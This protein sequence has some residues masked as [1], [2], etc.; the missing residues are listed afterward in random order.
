LTSG[1]FTSGSEKRNFHCSGFYRSG[2]SGSNR[3]FQ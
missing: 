2:Q 3:Q 1:D